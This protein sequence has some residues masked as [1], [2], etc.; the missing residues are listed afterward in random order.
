MSSEYGDPI[1]R[2]TAEVEVYGMA[3]LP[4]QPAQTEAFF[5]IRQ[6]QDGAH[7]VA[8]GLPAYRGDQGPPG[9]RPQV[10]IVPDLASIPQ[11]GTLTDNDFGKCWRVAGESTIRM[12]TEKGFQ[13]HPN[14]I[15]AQGE[16][17]ARGPANVLSEG[18]IEMLDEHAMPTIEITGAAPN[19]VL[20]IGIP[21]VPGRQGDV[22]PAAAIEASVDYDDDGSPATPGEVLTKF[23]DG[24]WGPQLPYAVIEEY[25]VPPSSFP[26]VS[27]NSSDQRHQLVSVP[28][29]AKPYDYRLGV[30]GSIEV[31][32]RA[33]H[34]VDIEV[35]LGNPT[36]G[37]L[38]GL[39]K[40]QAS[41]GWRDVMLRSH[42]EVAYQP[43]STIGVIPAG[44]AVTVYASAVL[45]SGFLW[46]WAVRNSYAQLR[47]QLLRAA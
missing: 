29:P 26:N 38:V 22:G 1:E 11:P 8:M 42:S 3:Q 13:I 25:V 20:H 19:Q 41:E 30:S 2:F 16:P 5:T 40:G 23:A 39:G 21:A 33:G 45:R 37:T 28:I 4:G 46:G 17:G 9:P 36:T 10:F 47:L 14:W 24:K 15:G 34:Q 35:R 27:K 31:D 44:T 12:W 6:R 7:E 32:N 18:V 43:G